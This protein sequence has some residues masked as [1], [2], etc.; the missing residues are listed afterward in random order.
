MYVLVVETRDS[1]FEYI[2]TELNDARYTMDQ[3]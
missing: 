3:D 2:T 1:L